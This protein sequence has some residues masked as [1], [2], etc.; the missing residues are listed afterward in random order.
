MKKL[1]RKYGILCTLLFASFVILAVILNENRKATLPETSHST[2]NMPYSPLS[3]VTQ[4]GSIHFQVQ[5]ATSPGERA[6]GLMFRKTLPEKTGM[7]FDF[8]PAHRVKM[9]MKNTFIPL[10]MLFIRRS[11]EII[12]IEENTE[13]H[14]TTIRTAPEPVAAVLEVSGGA[15]ARYG[16]KIGDIVRHPLFA[17]DGKNTLVPEE[18][19]FGTF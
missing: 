11:G 19:D 6:R 17:S 12:W 14:S 3:I 4:N 5:V 2:E 7:L 9:W 15:T 18:T 1:L 13:P 10:D 16:I 8:S